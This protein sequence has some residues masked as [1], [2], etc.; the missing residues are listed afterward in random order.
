MFKEL[1]KKY[2]NVYN[3]ISKGLEELG[4]KKEKENF[5]LDEKFWVLKLEASNFQIL[6]KHDS[7]RNESSFFEAKG[8]LNNLG[9]ATI[10]LIIIRS[11]EKEFPNSSVIF[12]NKIIENDELWKIV[13]IHQK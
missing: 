12:S 2:N 7:E 4:F 13:D 10:I 11:I 9:K 6:Y 3:T 1:E 5:I 8:D